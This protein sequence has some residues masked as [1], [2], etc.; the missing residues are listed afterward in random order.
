MDLFIDQN[1]LSPAVAQGRADLQNR[2]G[3]R[4]VAGASAFVV[5]R[6]IR[7]GVSLGNTFLVPIAVQTLLVC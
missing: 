2:H 7:S 4:R 3:A 1:L 6:A 5:I